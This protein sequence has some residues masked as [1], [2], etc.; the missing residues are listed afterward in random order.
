MIELSHHES[1]DVSC[2]DL[3]WIKIQLPMSANFD[4]MCG[5]SCLSNSRSCWQV[6]ACPTA[7]NAC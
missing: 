6:R 3:N 1:H 7:S 4:N 2:T 5:V